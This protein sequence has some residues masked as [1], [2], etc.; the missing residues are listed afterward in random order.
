MTTVQACVSTFWSVKPGTG[1]RHLQKKCYKGDLGTISSRV[2][3]D[4]KKKD[5]FDHVQVSPAAF[6]E[7]K[8]DIFDWKLRQLTSVVVATKLAVFNKTSGRPPAL[9]VG[10]K[11]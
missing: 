6:V 2:C 1:L 7:S 10:E 8:L 5:H 4:K 9:L 11:N 3:T